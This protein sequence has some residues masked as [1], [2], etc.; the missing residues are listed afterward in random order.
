[1]SIEKTSTALLFPGQ[2]AHYVGMG[3][4]FYDEFFN[5]RETFEI[6][7]QVA[8]YNMARL[9]FEDPQDRLKLTEYAQ[10]AILTVSLA[11]AELIEYYT[12]F[13]PLIKAAAGHSL[14]EI[15]ALAFGKSLTLAEALYLVITRAKAMQRAVPIGQGKMAAI[16]GLDSE[17]IQEVCQQAAKGQVVTPANINA[18]G[19]V[20]IAG[21]REAVDRACQL[22]FQ[23]GAKKTIAL[24]VSAPFHCPLMEPAAREFEQAFSRIKLQSAKIPV[25]RNVDNSPHGDPMAIQKFLIQQLTKPVNWP[26][27]IESLKKQGIQQFIVVCPGKVLGG[28]IRRIDRS[29]PLFIVDDLASFNKLASQFPK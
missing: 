2:A 12:G 3:N 16:I 8:K 26:G 20:V 22:S 18:P 23:A 13:I 14:G 21:H 7:S 17:K 6:A 5:V 29:L 4:D 27:L 10:P 1:M 11:V 24:E 28:L 9:C 25:Y 19:Q 15:S